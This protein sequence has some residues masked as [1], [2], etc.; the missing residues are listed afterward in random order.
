MKA[1]II[2]FSSVGKTTL[3]KILTKAHIDTLKFA[4]GRQEE[5]IGVATVP[6]KRL[7]QLAELFQPKKTTFA[8]VEYVDVAGLVKGESKEASHLGNVKNVDALVHVV[9]AFEDDAI[10]HPEGSLNPQRDIANLDLEL[11]L[12][13]LAIAEKRIERL[14][15]DVRK[16]KNP[17]LEKE[18]ELLRRCKASL[19]QEQPL[20]GLELDE[21]SRKILRGFMFLSEKPLLHVLNL[22][23]ADAAKVDQVVA[24]YRLESVAAQPHVGVTAVC[25]KIEAE[26][27]ELSG[28]D[29]AVFLA[30]YGLRESG[31]DRLI[32]ATYDLLGLISFLTVGEDECRAWTIKKGT[33]AVKAAGAIH[34]DIERGFIRAEVVRW[35]QLLEVK[36][37][38]VARDKALLRLEGKNY[39]VQDGDVINFRH[40][41]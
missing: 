24:S 41:G 25:G 16:M 31:L 32:R 23:D 37:L 3:F 35:D 12:S 28:E 20:R 13:D 29:A 11:L 14:E 19:E 40:S 27:V 36:S 1:G 39:V 30:D 15:K 26:L 21:E 8:T 33:P 6:D 4:G 7:E 17:L 38:A 22:A 18:L 5:H 10:P 9:R 2:G 34:S